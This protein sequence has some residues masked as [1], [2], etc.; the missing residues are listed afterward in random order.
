V[1]RVNIQPSTQAFCCATTFVRTS[2]NR[3]L[4]PPSPPPHAKT[5]KSIHAQQGDSLLTRPAI[6]LCHPDMTLWLEGGGCLLKRISR[7]GHPPNRGPGKRAGQGIDRATVSE[8]AISEKEPTVIPAPEWLV[9]RM[10][11]LRK[12]PPPTLEEVKTQLEASARF[13]ARANV[14][15]PG[16]E[17]NFARRAGPAS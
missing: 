13:R 9:E 7:G 1:I 6:Q 3:H 15:A 5:R 2:V 4:K 11:Q 12:L 16:S 14:T 10:E 17:C 8:K